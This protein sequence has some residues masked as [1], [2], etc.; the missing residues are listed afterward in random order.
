MTADDV[1]RFLNVSRARVYVAA[2]SDPT[3]PTPAA[4]HPRRWSRAKVEWA[5][6]RWWVC[7]RGGTVE[8]QTDGSG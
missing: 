6:R 7:G 8:A 1:A 5:E 4:E 3:F 2:E